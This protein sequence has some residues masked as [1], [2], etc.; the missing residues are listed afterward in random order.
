MTTEKEYKIQKKKARAAHA[1]IKNIHNTKFFFKLIPEK[2]LIPIVNE[3]DEDF[4]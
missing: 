4:Y 2:E 1:T 3:L